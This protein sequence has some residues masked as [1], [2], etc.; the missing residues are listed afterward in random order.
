MGDSQKPLNVP[1][2][3]TEAADKSMVT[4]Q[5]NPIHRKLLATIATKTMIAQ[6]TSV[7]KNT[8]RRGGKAETAC[9]CWSSYILVGFSI[10]K[11]EVF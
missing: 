4:M 1:P 11:V 8:G 10:S 2:K 5:S 9:W 7:G 3:A 6:V